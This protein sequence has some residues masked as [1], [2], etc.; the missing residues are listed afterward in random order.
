MPRA[1][2]ATHR[3]ILRLIPAGCFKIRCPSRLGGLIHLSCKATARRFPSMSPARW[4]AKPSS[5]T[6]TIPRRAAVGRRSS[7]T[8]GLD[9]LQLLCRT[10]SLQGSALLAPSS[11]RSQSVPAQWEPVA[12]ATLG[13]RGPSLWSKGQPHSRRLHKRH[14]HQRSLHQRCPKPRLLQRR[15]GQPAALRRKLHRLAAIQPAEPPPL[16]RR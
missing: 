3:S 8:R 14:Q 2:S 5:F 12:L 11:A 16:V 15:K 7:R 9:G 1:K 13:L 6:G 4:T 10:R